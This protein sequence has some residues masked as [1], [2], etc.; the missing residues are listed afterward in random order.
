[1]QKTTTSPMI[2]TTGPLE[3]NL[4]VYGIA[5]VGPRP[6]K[7]RRFRWRWVLELLGDWAGS[8]PQTESAAGRL[9]TKTWEEEPSRYSDDGGSRNC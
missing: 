6:L 4:M 1:M 2:T 3:H 7:L 8:W 5:N 9:D